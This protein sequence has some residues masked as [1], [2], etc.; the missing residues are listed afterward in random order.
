MKKASALLFVAIV[1]LGIMVGFSTYK[2]KAVPIG[3]VEIL[4]PTGTSDKV[5]FYEKITVKFEVSNADFPPWAY[6]GAWIYV[7]GVKVDTTSQG[8][9][10]PFEKGYYPESYVGVT[11]V[12]VTAFFFNIFTFEEDTVSASATFTVEPCDHLTDLEDMRIDKLHAKESGKVKLD[13]EGVTIC[14]I[15]DFLGCD[16]FHDMFHKSLYRS[17]KNDLYGDMDRRYIDIKYFKDTDSDG[18]FEEDWEEW[19]DTRYEK[20]EELYNESKGEYDKNT[21]VH[22]TYTLASLRQIAPGAKYIFI[23]AES[24][25]YIEKNATYWLADNYDTLGIDVVSIAWSGHEDW[26]D[27]S[28]DLADGGVIV[29]NAAGNGGEIFTYSGNAN[30]PCSFNNTIGVT[31]VYDSSHSNPWT[32]AP[33]VHG[34]NSGWG[35]DTAAIFDKMYLD[36]SPVPFINYF[37]GTSLACPMVAGIIALLKQY[38]NE[39]KSSVTFDYEFIQ[40]L[41]EETGDAPGNPPSHYE[42][43][44]YGYIEGFNDEGNGTNWWTFPYHTIGETNFEVYCYGWGIIDGYEM[45]K[46]FRQEY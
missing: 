11:T 20:W 41:L 16:N 30:Y 2:V 26:S 42:D 22:G 35:V 17:C 24:N 21:D 25:Y 7:G 44:D 29:V 9:G 14:I 34:A 1:T 46:Y 40:T 39:H 13:G 27:A 36:W 37:N 33:G 32:R 19:T 10:T 8:Y 15:D 18:D 38:R 28:E 43:D 4:K 6:T 5:L 31:G 12:T 23:E 45:Y 3:E